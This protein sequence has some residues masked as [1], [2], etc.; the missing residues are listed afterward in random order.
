MYCIVLYCIVL[1][2]IVLYCI[3]LYCIVLYCIVLYCIVLYCIVL[4]W[5][6][7]DWIG[8]ETKIMFML[9][10]FNQMILPFPFSSVMFM[11]KS[12]KFS[13]T[14]ISSSFDICSAFQD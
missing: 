6:G 11:Q 2:C 8:L 13:I 10:L 12:I 9:Y 3:V 5:I 1:Y 4:Y 14:V 7:L